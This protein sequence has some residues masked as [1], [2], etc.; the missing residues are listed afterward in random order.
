MELRPY[1]KATSFSASQEIPG[2]LWY[3]KV[4]YCVHKTP[5]RVPYCLD[6]V[7]F[8]VVPFMSMSSSWPLSF[9]SLLFREI[10]AVVRN[11]MER[12]ST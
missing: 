1:L 5:A 6:K 3:P 8:N 9:I 7:D 10:T 4:R 2:I 12:W 11:D